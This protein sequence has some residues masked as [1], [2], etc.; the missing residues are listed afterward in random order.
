M[1]LVYI[2]HNKSLFN[3]LSVEGGFPVCTAVPKHP[4]VI[5]SDGQTSLCTVG[6]EPAQRQPAVCL[7]RSCGQRMCIMKL[8]TSARSV[9]L[10][11]IPV[12]DVLN[13]ENHS[14]KSEFNFQVH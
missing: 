1:T 8:S 2:V 7:C 11:S 12:S 14:A 9:Y 4:E 3:F 10:W 6:H 13:W 5:I